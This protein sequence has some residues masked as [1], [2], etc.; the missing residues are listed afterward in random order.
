MKGS[1]FVFDHVQLLYYKFHK[2]NPNRGGLYINSSD[3]IKNKNA[4][5]NTLNVKDNKS[6][7]DIVTVALN[8]E[9]IK[10]KSANNNK[11]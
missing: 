6:F 3:W 1:E 8:H 7:Q 2:I 4:A 9:E 5:I 11:N 10:K